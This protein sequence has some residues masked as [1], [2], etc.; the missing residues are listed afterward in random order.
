MSSGTTSKIPSLNEISGEEWTRL[1]T[2]RIFF[3]HQSVGANLLEGVKDV[4]TRN[5]QIP[6][7]TA[8][9]SDGVELNGPALYHARIGRN[10]TPE[11]KLAEFANIVSGTPHAFDVALMKYC[12]VDIMPDT[13]PAVLFR[14]YRDRMT[15]LR[16]EWPELTIVHVTL[17]LL[18]DTGTLRYAYA[19][20]RRLPTVREVNLVREQYSQLIRST[21]GGREPLFDLAHLES[22]RTDGTRAVVRH[23]MGSVPVLASEWTY[24]GGHLNA[25]GRLWMAEML[26]ATLA[27]L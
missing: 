1:G 14:E 26:L 12:Y 16:E 19:R 3:G 6:L 11:S 15:R 24:D 4:I 13:D 21:Y 20:L 10:G 18:A 7:V 25:A 22:S 5:P 9:L 8:N 2:R 27:K 23:G 17:P